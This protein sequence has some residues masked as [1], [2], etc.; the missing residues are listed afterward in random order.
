MS[1]LGG[2]RV[3]RFRSSN[4]RTRQSRLRRQII[5]YLGRFAVLTVAIVL[6]KD[7]S[8]VERA[9]LFVTL[10]VSLMSLLVPGDPAVQI[11]GENATHEQIELTR[12]LSF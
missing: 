6:V 9:P 7:A 11:A 8:W 1:A 12:Q 10:L 3:P 5:R 2:L 4:R